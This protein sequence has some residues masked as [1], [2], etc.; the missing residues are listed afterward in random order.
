MVSVERKKVQEHLCFKYSLHFRSC[1]KCCKHTHHSPAY[2]APVA[3]RKVPL[4]SRK[5]Y[6]QWWRVMVM[7]FESN[8]YTH[9]HIHKHTHTRTHIYTYAYTHTH[10]HTH[11]HT[12]VQS[13]VMCCA[14]LTSLKEPM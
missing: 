2:M 7:L 5:P 1:Y 14:F 8:G 11:T 13:V 10:T 12:R 4:P 6:R 9:R 3:Y